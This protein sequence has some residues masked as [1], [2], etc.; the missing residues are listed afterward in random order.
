MA[1]TTGMV[2]PDDAQSVGSVIILGQFRA[3]D[4]GDMWRTKELE[5]M[6]PNNP[7]GTVD[8]LFA[9][10]HGAIASGS[11]PFVHGLRPRV[12]L[13]QNGTRKGAAPDP[14]KTILSS[15]GL[16]G[17][18]QMH[19]SYN[20][21]VDENAP[22]LFIANVDDAATIANILTAPPRGGGPGTAPAGAAPAG[23]P[24]AGI[25]PPPRLLQLPLRAPL[26]RLRRLQR[27]RQRQ[28]RRLPPQLDRLPHLLPLVDGVEETQRDMSGGCGIS[29]PAPPPPPPLRSPL[30]LRLRGEAD[31]DVDLPHLAGRGVVRDDPGAGVVARH[32]GFGHLGLSRTLRPLAGHD[33][34]GGNEFPLSRV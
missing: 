13:V 1:G 11:L 23:A 5:L 26:P 32:R 25:P 29:K 28:Q 19:W 18:W 22:G 14:V 21:G 30:C 34:G 31:F 10:S 6:C 24:A 4:F 3:A 12:V 20:L 8:L 27:P 7:L 33:T 9:S 2:D 16:E 17:L 15:P